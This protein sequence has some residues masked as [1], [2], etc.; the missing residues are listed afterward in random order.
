MKT[1]THHAAQARCYPICRNGVAKITYSGPLTAAAFNA[2]APQLFKETQEAR[3]LLIRMEG[4]LTLMANLGETL[5]NSYNSVNVPGCVIVREDQRDF[6]ADYAT[7]L[8]KQGVRRLVF[9]DSQLPLALDWLEQ[10]P[11]RNALKSL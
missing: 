8:S 10:R 1:F 4:C 6:W 5:T 9:L 11:L 3:S 2:L 7:V